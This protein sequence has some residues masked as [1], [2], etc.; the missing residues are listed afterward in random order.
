MLVVSLH[1]SEE[2]NYSKKAPNP[3]MLL[4]E[5]S[6]SFPLKLTAEYLRGYLATKDSYLIMESV[7]LPVSLLK[8]LT[9][10]TNYASYV[11]RYTV[12]YFCICGRLYCCTY[13]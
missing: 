6:I 9:L 2:L 13:Y 5:Y 11:R 3:L 8:F 10:C 12:L 7:R 1:K 4:T